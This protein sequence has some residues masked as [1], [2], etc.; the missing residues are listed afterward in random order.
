M[1]NHILSD[2]KQSKIAEFYFSYSSDTMNLCFPHVKHSLKKQ[3]NKIPS[4]TQWSMLTISAAAPLGSIP[5][6]GEKKLLKSE[7][8][9]IKDKMIHERDQG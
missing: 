9:W 4:W 3:T 6:I 1:E 2:S 5:T 7:M 8:L